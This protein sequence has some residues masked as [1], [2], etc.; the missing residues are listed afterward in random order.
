MQAAETPYT[1]RLSGAAE[2]P[3]GDPDGA[4][5]AA[6]SFANLSATETEICWD[7]NYS[8]IAAATAAHIHRGVAGVNGAV[9]VALV[10]V[11][12]TSAKGCVPVDP[13]LAAEIEATPA[14]FYVNVH[15][16]EFPG[17]AM[18]GQLAKGPAA[19]GSLHFLP[20]PL[21]A[22]DSRVTGQTKLAAGTTRT[23]SLAN[24]KD[25]ADATSIA[26]PPGATGAVVTLTA[27]QTTGPDGFLKLYSA[28]S[29][30]PATSS[31]NWSAANQH[32]AVST[33][34]AVDATGQVKVT[35]GGTSTHFIIDVIGYYY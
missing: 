26:V 35:T 1:T 15:N 21:R 7:V 13:A 29:T 19:T 18:R 14:G 4:G 12:A 32:I 10:G 9:V 27:T 30:E 20:T 11:A 33:Q 22:Y 5:A 34:V 31:I 28:T 8:A 17:G 23:V 3:V 16:A 2:S 24:G 6:I 25:L